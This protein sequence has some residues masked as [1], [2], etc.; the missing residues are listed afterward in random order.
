LGR[1][2]HHHQGSRYFGR[3]NGPPRCRRAECRPHWPGRSPA[4]P[5]AAPA[6]TGAGQSFD[7]FLGHLPRQRNGCRSGRS[8]HCRWRD[9]AARLGGCGIR[10]GGAAVG[11]A[12]RQQHIRPRLMAAAMTSHRQL[13]HDH[14]LGPALGFMVVAPKPDHWLADLAACLAPCRRFSAARWRAIPVGRALSSPFPPHE[15]GLC[16][17]TGE[18]AS[19]TRRDR[20]RLDACESNRGSRCGAPDAQVDVGRRHRFPSLAFQSGAGSACALAHAVTAVGA[21]AI[22][23]VGSLGE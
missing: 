21:K 22:A 1:T 19:L 8:G 18:A 5:A 2:A 16:L 12:Q 23:Y 7:E 4:A 10:S 9:G 3:P 6:G 17:A 14:Q 11:A 13:Q 15:A 20:I